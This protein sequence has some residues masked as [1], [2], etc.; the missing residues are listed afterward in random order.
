MRRTGIWLVGLLLFWMGVLSAAPCAPSPTALCLN[1]SRFRAEVSW[2][3][4]HGRTINIV[5]NTLSQGG[6][7]VAEY[8]VFTLT[9][10]PQ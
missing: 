10:T 3:D 5:P 4:S 6:V 9:H 1:G 2:R 7:S 8:T